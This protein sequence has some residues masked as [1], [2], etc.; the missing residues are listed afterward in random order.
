MATNVLH[1]L[2]PLL[3]FFLA[4]RYFVQGLSALGGVS[5]R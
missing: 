5:Q 3:V 2:P 4:Q 1:M